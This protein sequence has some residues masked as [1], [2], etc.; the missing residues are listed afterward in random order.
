MRAQSEFPIV[1]MSG[2]GVPLI[3]RKAV[4]DG[5]IPFLRK[6]FAEKILISPIKEAV[7]A[8]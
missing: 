1:F 8:N 5:G 2:L 3:E 4:A 7:G 6:P